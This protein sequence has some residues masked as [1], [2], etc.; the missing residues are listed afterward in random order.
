MRTAHIVSLENLNS[1]FE[2]KFS[3]SFKLETRR[4]SHNRLNSC[5]RHN[6]WVSNVAFHARGACIIKS[7]FM[8]A[9]N[10]ERESKAAEGIS[11]LGINRA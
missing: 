1:L 3:S 5:R 6:A 7:V 4:V 9:H 11:D 8:I 2:I 10:P